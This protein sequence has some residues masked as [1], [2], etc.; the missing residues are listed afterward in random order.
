MKRRKRGIEIHPE[1]IVQSFIATVHKS[2]TGFN[3]SVLLQV[4]LSGSEAVDVGGVRRLL[5]C[6]LLYQFATDR[7]L[8]LFEGGIH[9]GIILP[10]VNYEA[11]VSGHFKLFGKVLVHSLLQEGPSLP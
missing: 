2:G 8:A 7:R 9:T 6:V 4:H 3:V 11:I 1:N 5:L 10:A